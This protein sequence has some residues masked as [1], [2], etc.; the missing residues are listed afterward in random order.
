MGGTRAGRRASE[1]TVGGTVRAAVDGD[2]LLLE[3][4]S[5]TQVRATIVRRSLV[6]AASAELPSAPAVTP[7]GSSSSGIAV[8]GAGQCI[9]AVVNGVCHGTPSPEA[10]IGMR[11]GTVPV[12][13]GQMLNGQCTGP[14]F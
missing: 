2:A 4:P 9:G 1:L 5:G 14:M 8:L 3:L 10:Q 13:H 6:S 7:P 11:T 12:C